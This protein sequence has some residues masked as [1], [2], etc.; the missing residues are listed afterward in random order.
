[1]SPQKSGQAFARHIFLL[2]RLSLLI[3]IPSQH[4]KT[5]S[6]WH[7]YAEPNEKFSLS[8]SLQN[9]IQDNNRT[10]YVQSP[11]HHF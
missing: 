8:E 6:E 4:V 5:G 9:A 11:M 7:R 1:M 3:N 2:R 10:H